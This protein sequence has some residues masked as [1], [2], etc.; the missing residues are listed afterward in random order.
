ME[1]PMR[2]YVIANLEFSQYASTLEPSGNGHRIVGN[3]SHDVYAPEGFAIELAGGIAQMKI[4]GNLLR[5][6]GEAGLENGVGFYIAGFG[7]NQDIDF[8]WNEIRD[9]GGRRAI[10][11]FGHI[12]GDRMDN[13]RIHDNLIAGSLP[14][15]N[16]ILLGGTDG[17]TEVLGTIYVYNII[18][19][20]SAWE[21]LRVNDPQ[22]T[23]IIQNNVLYNNGSQGIDSNAQLHI[24]RAGAGGITL[25]NNVLYA[26]SGQTYFQFGTGVDS[27]VF[28][29]V[30]NNL[31]Y[32]AGPCRPGIQLRQR[33]SAVRESGGGKVRSTAR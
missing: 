7:T 26:E 31:V 3:Y 14:L 10:Q 33:R 2:Y 13:I 27:A 25:Q 16:N 12:A 23:F 32:N 17:G 28:N 30:S 4:F 6:N 5:N 24:E 9:Q 19:V 8:G 11:L 29:A 18:V 15:R 22:G 21:G 1:P 20:G